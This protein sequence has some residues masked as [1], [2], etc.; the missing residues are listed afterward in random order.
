MATELLSFRLSGD[1]LEWLKSQQQE[2]ET[3]NLTAKRLLLETM[4]QTVD[5]PVDSVVDTPEL[6]ARLEKKIEEK[7]EAMYEQLANNINYIL[8]TRLPSEPKTVDTPV[9]TVVD[10]PK[11]PLDSYT[12]IELRNMAKSLGIPYKVRDSKVVLIREISARKS[13]LPL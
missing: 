1:E 13:T 2:S 8:D 11:K 5:T 4:K 6:E 7:I 12:V 9:D 3:L 10:T